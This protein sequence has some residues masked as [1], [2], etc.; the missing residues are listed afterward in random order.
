MNR[1]V[2]TSM[3]AITPIGTNVDTFWE[4]NKQGTNGIEKITAF[5]TSDFKVKLAGEIKDYSVEKFLDKREAKRY[6]RFCQFAMIA[7]EEAINNSKLDLGNIDKD[8]FGVAV[9]SGI[10]GFNT[11]EKEHKNLIEKGPRR[12]SPLF[13]P[14][15]IGNIAGGNI[16]V[17]YGAKGSVLN[18]VTA[19]ATGTHSI[20]EAYRMIKHGYMD[21][22]I[23]GGCEASITPLSLAGFTSLTALS[24]SEDVNK[25]SIPFNKNRSGF[26]MGEGSGVLLLESLEHAKKRG[27]T[28]LGEIVGYGSTCDAYHM[29]SPHPNGEGSK[30]AMKLAINEAGIENKD[31]G[32]INAHGTGTPYN[33]K[34]ETLAIK[35][36]L[37][38]E[39]YNIPISSTKSM[40]G[41]LLGAA[42][43]VESI[44]CIKALQEGFIPPTI[45]LDEK[46]EDC[47]L[48]YV[49]NVGIK[50][51]IKYAMSN[52]LGFGGHNATLLF[53]K[54][55][56]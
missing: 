29:T 35:G 2:I 25:A 40:T 51:E 10:G 24:T 11:L 33:D 41:H 18:I 20:G 46:D 50:R 43:A 55:E 48:N 8:R 16:A 3:G 27:A 49:P 54:W 42:G 6:D 34:F 14:M 44:V 26:V 13:I 52:S 15:M 21:L 23:A 32:Y 45:N 19:C 1:V 28:I 47:D 37:E 4:A 9:G 39:A 56:E 5:D 30:K 31:L 38:E 36:A 53:K 7:T 22:M 12:V 17:K